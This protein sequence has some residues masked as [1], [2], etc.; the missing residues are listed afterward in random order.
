[1]SR[2]IW[3]GA[4]ALG[5]VLALSGVSSA[6][7][8]DALQ[9]SGG[10]NGGTT[11]T[12]GGKGTIA[13]AATEDTELTG[14]YHGYHGYRGWGGGYGYRGYYGGYHGHYHTGYYGGYHGYYRPYYGNYFAFSYAR[15]YYYPAYYY[16]RPYYSS[17]YGPS[18]GFY[19]GI[20]GGASTAAPA[21]NLGTN[22][23]QPMLPPPP[24]EGTFPYDGGPVNPVPQPLPDAKPIP[25]ANPG[26][27]SDLP[28]SGKAKPGIAP[29]TTP[30]KYKAFGEK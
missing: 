15:P 2:N 5:A 20:N 10:T 4:L 26:T 8:R 1:M 6:G 14:G 16:P 28:I 12:L 18:F 3:K 27:V 24:P 30:Y 19:I 11:M 7:E 17:Y 21:V 23:A 13:Q 25:P 22:F 9:P 29:A